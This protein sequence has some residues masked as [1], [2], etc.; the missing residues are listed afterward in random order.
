MIGMIL[1]DEPGHSAAGSGAGVPDTDES[2]LKAADPAFAGERPPE[3]TKKSEKKRTAASYAISFF[4]KI[5]ITAAV[6]WLLLTY[7]VCVLICHTN[8]AYPAIKDGDFCL[9]FRL[10]KPEQGA[11][12]AYL[13]DGAMRFGRVIASGGDRVS[14]YTDYITVNDCCISDETVYPTSPEGSAVSYPYTVPDNC[15]FVLNERRSDLTDS[16]TF[17][18]IPQEELRGTVVFIMRIRGI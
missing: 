7:A 16:R 11:M 10:A 5:G 4:I 14:I 18:G 12:I 3:T 2:Y 9:T 17:G 6:L 8:S 1:T 15:V 13:H